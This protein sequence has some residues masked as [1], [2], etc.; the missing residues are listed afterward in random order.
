MSHV[1]GIDIKVSDLACLEAAAEK[2]CDLVAVR[3][4]EYDW[5]GAW[6]NDY[7]GDNAA[8]KMGFDGCGLRSM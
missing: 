1:V 4:T 3:T 7:H 2:S 6:L 8:Y 5:W